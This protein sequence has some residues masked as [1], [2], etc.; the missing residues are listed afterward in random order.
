MICKVDEMRMFR[1]IC[2]GQ[3]LI[4]EGEDNCGLVIRIANFNRAYFARDLRLAERVLQALH[5][6]GASQFEAAPA[7]DAATQWREFWQV[8][9]FDAPSFWPN[10][11]TIVFAIDSQA[12]IG[13]QIR[14]YSTIKSLAGISMPVHV[15]VPELGQIRPTLDG[16]IASLRSQNEPLPTRNGEGASSSGVCELPSETYSGDAVLNSTRVRIVSSFVGRLSNVNDLVDLLD[17]YDIPIIYDWGVETEIPSHND[18]LVALESEGYQCSFLIRIAPDA[19][20]DPTRHQLLL[21][22]LFAALLEAPNREFEVRLTRPSEFVSLEH[23]RRFYD[24]LDEFMHKALSLDAD[25][26]RLSIFRRYL[27][28]LLNSR[29]LGNILELRVDGGR[30]SLTDWCTGMPI[31]SRLPAR[32]KFIEQLTLLDLAVAKG[33]M[34]NI[35][36]SCPLDLVCHKIPFMD[37]SLRHRSEDP[38]SRNIFDRECS[39]HK[40]VVPELIAELNAVCNL[41]VEGARP[42]RLE[43]TDT[44]EVKYQPLYQ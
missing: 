33:G 37:F 39:I 23:V 5:D 12:D 19:I 24:G 34:E 17:Q 38:I 15:N 13:T 44:K 3:Y 22:R 30:F 14:W 32:T 11:F 42:L 28:N 21:D 36:T 9:F 40:W 29:F 20:A 31:A 41:N 4:A 26:S 10:L 7:T 18:R 2:E 16:L 1:S 8:G 27:N 43:I 25:V 35:C 6:S